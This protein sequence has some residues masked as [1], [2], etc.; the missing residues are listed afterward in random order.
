MCQGAEP[1][2]WPRAQRVHEHCCAA[3]AAALL[4]EC[5]GSGNLGD[6]NAQSD[7]VGLNNKSPAFF[8]DNDVPWLYT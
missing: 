8:G 6:S 2:C 5:A 1:Q 3:A 4:P 7:S